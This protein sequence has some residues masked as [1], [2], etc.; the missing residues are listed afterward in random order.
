MTDDA[1]RYG[2][3]FTDNFS[4][5]RRMNIA[6]DDFS[7]QEIY[8]GAPNDGFGLNAVHGWTIGAT[9]TD[10]RVTFFIDDFSLQHVGAGVHDKPEAIISNVDYAINELPMYGLREKTE[11]Q[12]RA[13]EDYIATMTRDGRT[14]EDA[15][16]VAAKNAWNIF[17]AG[18][19]RNAIRRFNQAWLLDP[20]N[21]LALWGFAVTCVDRG[22]LEQADDYYRMAIDSG[23]F[24]P[25]LE[26]D[27]RL[28]QQKLASL[29]PE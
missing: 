16:Q 18:D 2:Y 17:Y 24:N 14:R 9:Q 29:P 19:K 20:D 6:F 22:Q 23:P 21:Q 26:R 1:E 8:N 10:G 11:A 4:G 13:D 27:Y 15:A 12:K 7:R 25:A 3:A 5:W 28:L